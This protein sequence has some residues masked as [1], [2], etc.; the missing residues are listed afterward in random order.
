MGETRP[1]HVI[2]Y[3]RSVTLIDLKDKGVS[4]EPSLKIFQ[5]FIE[6]MKEHMR[7]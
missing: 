3:G 4:G 5:S 6:G 2:L 7:E 1:G